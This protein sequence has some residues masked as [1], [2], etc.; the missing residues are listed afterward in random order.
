[1]TGSWMGWWG[2]LLPFIGF[3]SWKQ[4]KAFVLEEFGPTEMPDHK[5]DWRKVVFVQGA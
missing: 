5:T 2:Y 3:W 1:M 4:K